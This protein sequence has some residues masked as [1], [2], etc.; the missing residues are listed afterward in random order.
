[1]LSFRSNAAGRSHLIP[2]R[3]DLIKLGGFTSLSLH[4]APA[5]LSSFLFSFNA[6]FKSLMR[7]QKVKG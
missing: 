4:F 3:E 6:F 5:I 7:F 1:M 2:A